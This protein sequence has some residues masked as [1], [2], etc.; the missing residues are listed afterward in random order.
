MLGLGFQLYLVDP[1]ILVPLFGSPCFLLTESQAYA[2]QA[3]NPKPFKLEAS[4][5]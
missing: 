5:N 3:R 1:L 2:W 4:G